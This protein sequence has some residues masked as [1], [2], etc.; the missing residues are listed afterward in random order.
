M[1]TEIMYRLR[2][3]DE[4]DYYSQGTRRQIDIE[5]QIASE[6][7]TLKMVNGML[8]MPHTI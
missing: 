1:E 4:L 3:F 8:L 5:H 6:W 7:V 2:R